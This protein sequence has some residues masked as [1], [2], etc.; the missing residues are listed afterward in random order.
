MSNGESLSK[1]SIY[2]VSALNHAARD[3]L[4]S[5]F[6]LIW[7]EGEISNLARPASGHIYFSLKDESAQLRCAMFKMRNRQVAFRPENGQQVLVQGRLSVYPARGDYQLIA[8][9]ME[10]AG[11]G[12]LRRQFELLKQRLQA[13]GLFAAERKQPL[14]TLP[15][16]LG[17]ITSPSGAAIH[18]ILHVLQRRFPGI[19]VLIYPVPVQGAEAPGAIVEALRT[20]NTCAECDVLILARGGGSLED[21]WAFNDEAVARAIAASSIPVV[22]AVGHEV[23]VSIADF[24]ADLRA[25]TPSAAAELVSPDRQEWLAVCRGWR[26]RLLRAWQGQMAHRRQHLDWLRRQLKHPDQRLRD[27]AQRL[28][29]LEQRLIL[30][31]RSRLQ[32]AHARLDTL[33]TRLHA[34][35]PARRLR[36]LH[37]RLDQLRHA[38]HSAIKHSL[39]FNRARLDNL[40]R[41]LNAVSPLATLG[42]GFAIV[43]TPDGRVVR[44]AQEL[45]VGDP[46]RARLG[47]GQLD[48]RVEAVH[49]ATEEQ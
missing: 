18:D 42:R 30:A 28:D 21:L 15:R 32:Q 34:H 26:Q 36:E 25:P 22:S 1:R 41:A 45:Q 38:N 17:I 11:D 33:L 16:R 48:C 5:E 10:A 19:P 39:S 24:A 46:V 7:V 27:R 20:A 14:P 44:N 9:H 35:S 49:E 12:T 37:L 6:P 23:D 2:S 43:Q 47:S 13:E 8:E 31:Q 4:E 3:L 40:A 29:E